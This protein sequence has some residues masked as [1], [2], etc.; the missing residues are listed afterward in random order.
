MIVVGEA[1]SVNS[2]GK[3]NIVLLNP[4]SKLHEAFSLENYPNWVLAKWH[5]ETRGIFSLTRF[6][7]LRHGVADCLGWL[8]QLTSS[9]GRTQYNEGRN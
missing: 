5:A 9:K 1:V 4:I 8:P 7:F 6:S 2:A 3:L